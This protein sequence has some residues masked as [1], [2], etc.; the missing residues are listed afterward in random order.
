MLYG[1]CSD[2]ISKLIIYYNINQYLHDL[3]YQTFYQALWYLK[4]N[5]KMFFSIFTGPYFS[6]IFCH[7]ECKNTF[8]LWACEYLKFCKSLNLFSHSC[9]GYFEYLRIS[10]FTTFTY[11][12]TR[13]M[14]KAFFHHN[15]TS[16]NQCI[17]SF[18]SVSKVILAR[19][20]SDQI[21]QKKQ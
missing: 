3:V 20:N 10:L 6:Y 8:F 2:L 15:A 12:K 1:N 11:F 14:F 4:K 9:H 7:I 21:S 13:L 16:T 5:F 18:F 17:D 19:L